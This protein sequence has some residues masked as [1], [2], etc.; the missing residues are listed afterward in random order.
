MMS[1]IK[2]LAIVAV[3]SLAAFCCGV[4]AGF[5]IQPSTVVSGIEDNPTI[6]LPIYDLACNNS[7]VYLPLSSEFIISLPENGGST[8]YTWDPTS[9][10]GIDLLESTFI[11]SDITVIGAPGTREFLLKASW[12]GEQHFKATLHRQ[13]ENLTGSEEVFTLTIVVSDNIDP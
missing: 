3:F 1:N 13:C 11:P 5:A 6:P 7:T 2:I 10:Q 9:T 4:A 12:A 8:G